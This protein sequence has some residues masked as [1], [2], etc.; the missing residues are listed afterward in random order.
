MN[1]MYMSQTDFASWTCAELPSI[2][3]FLGI[4]A[5]AGSG[6]VSEDGIM[7]ILLRSLA[8]LKFLWMVALERRSR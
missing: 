3:F 5:T 2:D 6:L 8:I 4:W 1:N 7:P